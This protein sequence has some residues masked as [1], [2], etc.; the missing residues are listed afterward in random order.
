MRQAMKYFTRGLNSFAL[1]QNPWRAPNIAGSPSLG[2]QAAIRNNPEDRSS[3]TLRGGSLK[4]RVNFHQFYCLLH[5]SAFGKA[6]N[7]A[8]KKTTKRKKK[9]KHSP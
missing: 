7:Q 1:E 6:I 5:V 3:Q 4:P 9:V 8:I 2:H